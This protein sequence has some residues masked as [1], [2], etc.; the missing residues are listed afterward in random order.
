[1]TSELRSHGTRTLLALGDSYTIGEAVDAADRWPARLA[2]RLR[3]HGV[4]VEDPVI[5]AQTGWTTDEL[6]DAIDQ[7]SIEDEFDLVTLLIGVNN[8]YRGRS[9]DEYRSELRSLLQRAISF[10]AARP[11]RVIVISIPDW[12]VT[13]FGLLSGRDVARISAEIDEFNAIV[14]A[15]ASRAGARFVD[16]TAISRRA[17]GEADLVAGDGLHPSGAMYE[18]WTTLILPA[19]IE[20][21][22]SDQ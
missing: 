22:D 19:A 4:A 3:A 18:E 2:R 10:A 14:R 21:L 16:V 7:A 15:E 6:N 9:P 17:H 1:M 12:G 8:Q 20:V 5:V 13:P 11:S